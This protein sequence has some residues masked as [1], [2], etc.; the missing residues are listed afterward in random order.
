MS[1]TFSMKRGSFESLNVVV[2]CGCN[3]NARQMRLIA[4]W[5]IPV[6]TAIARVLQCVASRGFVSR[7]RTITRSTSASE[8]LRG[9]PGRGSSRRP[10]IPWETK[11]RRHLP[12]V[13]RFTPAR[14]AT[15]KSS[16]PSA[17]AKTIRARRA[18]ACAVVALLVQRV[19]SS[20]CTSVSSTIRFGRPRDMRHLPRYRHDER[21][22]I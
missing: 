8:I 5:L 4:D 18:K 19:S 6:S 12:T 3:E 1:R 16:P 7:V 9:A 2:R 10:S 21:S 15:T 22:S 20:R 11:R 17:H 14:S 13:V